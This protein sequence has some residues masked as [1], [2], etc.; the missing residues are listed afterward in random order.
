MSYPGQSRFAAELASI[1]E[2]GLFKAERI[3]VSPQSAEIELEGGRK[4]WPT[5]LQ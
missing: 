5:T 1:R 3:I 4:A 2:Q